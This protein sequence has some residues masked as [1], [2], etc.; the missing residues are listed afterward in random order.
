[1][2]ERLGGEPEKYKEFVKEN[3]DLKGNELIELFLEKN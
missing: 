1:M 3:K 2:S